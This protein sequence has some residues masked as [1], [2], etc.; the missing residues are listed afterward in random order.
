MNKVSDYADTVESVK[1]NNTLYSCGHKNCNYVSSPDAKFFLVGLPND[2][3]GEKCEV[4]AKNMLN[5]LND[6]AEH[7]SNTYV[8]DLFNNAEIFDEEFDKKYAL[9][10]HLNPMGYMHFAE[11]IDSYI[12][13]IIRKNPDEFKYAGLINSG[14]EFVK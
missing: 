5:V 13:Y 8:L 6:F 1:R 4:I 10:G 12:D 7:F 14:I 9:N 11:I 3:R 2:C